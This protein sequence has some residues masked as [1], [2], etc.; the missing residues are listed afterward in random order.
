MVSGITARVRECDDAQPGDDFRGSEL[1]P[2]KQQS[3][4][5]RPQHVF[6]QWSARPSEISSSLSLSPS[7]TSSPLDSG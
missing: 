6:T 4:H 3:R 1:V 5:K 7:L 2:G